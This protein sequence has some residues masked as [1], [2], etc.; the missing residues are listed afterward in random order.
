MTDEQAAQT[1]I[2]KS[3]GNVFADLNLPASP[4]D[5][6]KI[7]IA[8]A[9][10]KILRVKKLTQTQAAAIIGTDQAKISA[11]LRGRLTGFS[12]DRLLGY[13]LALGLNV[14][15]QFS[16]NTPGQRG[17]MRVSRAA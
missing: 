8:A 15:I 1:A 6:L 5:M 12:T 11:L 16:D 9:I 14:D 3:S 2:I 17:Q 13:V 7:E 4:E 10:A